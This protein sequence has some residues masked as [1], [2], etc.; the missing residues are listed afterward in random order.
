MNIYKCIKDVKVFDKVLYR[1]GDLIDIDDEN[2]VSRYKDEP[3]VVI[4]YTDP[5][6]FTK[7]D[8]RVDVGDFV[9]QTVRG[10]KKR[11]GQIVDFK[12]KNQTLVVKFEDRRD[13]EEVNPNFVVPAERYFFI[14]SEGKIQKTFKGLN[15]DRDQYLTLSGRMWPSKKMA[16]DF[17]NHELAE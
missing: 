13:I 15:E 11:Y 8:L 16:Q 3:F 12:T 4:P 10:N 2:S 5:E 6:F 7:Y 14:S 1:K 17:L 9:C